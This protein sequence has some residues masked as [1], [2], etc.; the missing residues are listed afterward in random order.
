ME[1]LLF[2]GVPILKHIRVLDI[3]NIDPTD[4]YFIF[5]NIGTFHH[6]TLG[7]VMYRGIKGRTYSNSF[8]DNES[9][10]SCFWGNLLSFIVNR[11]F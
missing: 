3:L 9:K 10:L 6:C 11:K 5:M 7:G 4:V 2:L 8:E 1:N